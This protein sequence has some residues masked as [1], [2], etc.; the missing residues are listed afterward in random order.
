MKN[1]EKSVREVLESNG[2]TF[3]R[4]GAGEYEIWQSAVTGKYFPVD[5]EIKSRRHA[6]IVLR[7][8]GV[9]AVDI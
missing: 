3:V 5:L 9:M 4:R 6:N 1:Y 8:G 7:H 2:C